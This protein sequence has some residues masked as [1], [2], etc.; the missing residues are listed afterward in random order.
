MLWLFFYKQDFSLLIL[1]PHEPLLLIFLEAFKWNEM[2]YYWAT[3]DIRTATLTLPVIV[4]YEVIYYINTTKPKSCICFCFLQPTS[5]NPHHTFLSFLEILLN[6][7]QNK[8]TMLE[9]LYTISLSLYVYLY[10]LFF[11]LYFHTALCY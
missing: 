4:M 8:V 11:T 10:F 6:I 2:M 7:S 3:K 1:N 5:E 9:E